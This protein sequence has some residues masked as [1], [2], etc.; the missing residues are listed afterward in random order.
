MAS[1][2]EV[3]AGAAAGAYPTLKE[4]LEAAER[5]LGPA[6]READERSLRYQRRFRRT[7]LAIIYGGV[8]AVG[9]GV[10]AGLTETGSLSTTLAVGE[11][12]LAAALGSLAFI[13]RNLRWHKRWL[14]SR[15]IAEKLRGE[16]F[17]FVGRLGIYAGASEPER[18]LRQRLVESR[19]MSPGAQADG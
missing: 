18:T 8:V 2:A 9:L 16:R 13:A 12:V 17:L 5:V 19:R 3:G 10:V 7:E 14:E 6:Y 11:A 15:W 4:D 1:S